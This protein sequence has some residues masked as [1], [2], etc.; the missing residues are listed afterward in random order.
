VRAFAIVLAAL[1]IAFPGMA[2]PAAT[3]AAEDRS[4][5]HD[6]DFLRGD[7]RVRHRYLRVQGDQR[8]WVEIDGTCRNDPLLEGAANLEEHVFQRPGG[9]TRALGL[10]AYDP[11][12]ALWS[13]WWVDG[14]DPAGAMDPPMKGR[15]EKGVGLFYGPQPGPPSPTRLRFTW[16]GVTPT[17]ARWEQA[18]S[19][20]E[21]KTWETVWIME[22]RR[23]G[24]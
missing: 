23:A 20:D 11:K 6:F 1:A 4:G 7:W 14:R 12:T 17:S 22:F 9:V 5:L 13:I 16:S 24:A 3:L 2:A 19:T 15:F 21:G 18:V 10:R 8:E